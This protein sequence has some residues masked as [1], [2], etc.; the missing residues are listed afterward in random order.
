MTSRSFSLRLEQE[1][2][3]LLDRGLSFEEYDLSSLKTEND[4]YSDEQSGFKGS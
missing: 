3:E 4:T 1:M 2:S